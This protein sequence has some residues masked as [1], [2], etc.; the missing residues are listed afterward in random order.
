MAQ[1]VNRYLQTLRR[2]PDDIILSVATR[3]VELDS[4]SDCVC[5]WVYREMRARAANTDAEVESVGSGLFSTPTRIT[6]G[7]AAKFGGVEEE[8]A[9]IFWGV[10][11]HAS[12]IELAFTDRVLEAVERAS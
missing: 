10:E 7:L 8:W 12:E 4:F 5:G 9:D 6:E 11:W 3:D 1:S 2:V